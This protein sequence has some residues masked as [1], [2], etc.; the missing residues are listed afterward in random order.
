M[1]TPQ[2]SGAERFKKWGW[3]IAILLWLA[4]WCGSLTPQQADEIWDTIP[5]EIQVPEEMPVDP[6]PQP[7]P[8]DQETP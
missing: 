8:V 4:Q 2:N 3:L 7:T 1:D 6:D 5:Q